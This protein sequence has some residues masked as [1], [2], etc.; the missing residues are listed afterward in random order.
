MTDNVTEN[1]IEERTTSPVV[2]L[3][4]NRNYQILWASQAISIFGTNA[5][6]IAFPLLVLALTGSPA[7][8]GIVL[9]VAAAAELVGGLPAGALA[10]RWDRKKIML[11]C[12]AIET[13]ATAGLILALWWHVASI[14]LLAVVAAIMGGC[15]SVFRPAETA[16][17]PNIVPEQQVGGAVAMNSARVYLGNLSGTAAGGFLFAI[18]RLVPFAANLVAH[19]AS[20]V[21][22]LFLRL[23]A[24][25]TPAPAPVGKL[26]AEMA[27]GL[28]FMWRHRHIRVTILCAVVLNLFFSAF[29]IVIIV[30]ARTRGVPSGEIGVMAAMLGVGGI[31]GSLAAPYLTKVLTPYQS[32]IGVFWV[33]TALTPVT[34]F[35]SNGYLIGALFA[36]M[37][38][39][40]P[41]ANTAIMTE[42]LLL[43]PD[44]MRGRLTG[45]FGV[46]AGLA[47]TVGPALGGVLVQL[48][49]DSG[50][51]L[52]CATGIALV[53]VAV[54]VSPTLRHFPSRRG[55][56]V[57]ESPSVSVEKGT[58]HG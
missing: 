48:M 17:L 44:D 25:D 37:A 30:V 29:Y 18:G 53:S 19:A 42:Q 33:L 58:T 43:T 38:L 6:L 14:A 22:L 12:E 11:L 47:S 7:A 56:T 57:T 35:I 20:F 51:V 26:G 27:A 8:S 55:G 32:I 46:L 54:T 24:R 28:A 10:D 49:S 40:P 23:P 13:V 4:R 9:G 34:V 31:L 36:G 16:T 41:A 3:A 21:A 5:I 15:E 52:F 45:V 1:D 2:P 39:L 50:A